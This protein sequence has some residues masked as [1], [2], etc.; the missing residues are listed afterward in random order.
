MLWALP[1]VARCGPLATGAYLKEQAWYY[2]LARGWDGTFLYQG[3]PVG[4][5][6]HGKYQGWDCTGGYLL[7]YALPLNSL[8]LTGKHPFSVPAFNAAQVAEVIAAGRDFGYKDDQNSY[9]R[10]TTEQLLTGLSSWSPSVRKRS[11]AAL[12]RRQDDVVPVLLKLLAGSSRDARYGA[13]EALGARGPRADAAA[14]QL[15]ALL[16][17][18]D[19]WMQSLAREALPALGA[20]ARKASVSDLL[21]MTVRP[22]P[23]DPRRMAQRAA[24]RRALLA[25]PRSTRA[26]EHPGRV[27]RGG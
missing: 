14:P 6:E 3:S 15:R 20:E 9:D 22:N 10:R 1:G 13:C 17:D 27:A 4:E 11:A 24:A 26:Q 18:P 7:A 12:G 2:D 21:A 5:E 8:L 23:A 19:P 25:L 16:K